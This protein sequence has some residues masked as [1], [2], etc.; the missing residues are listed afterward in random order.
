MHVRHN[1]STELK[2]VLKIN[3]KKIRS[4][5]LKSQDNFNPPPPKKTSMEKNSTKQTKLI[6]F[7][8][9]AYFPPIKCDCWA[10]FKGQNSC[11]EDHTPTNEIWLERPRCPQNR[12]QYCWFHG[13]WNALMD[14][15]NVEDARRSSDTN[16]LLMDR[17][18]CF[19]CFYF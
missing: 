12:F 2:T 9:V 3:K 8:P 4:Y 6:F 10:I 17:S 11:W 16:C 14:V 13:Y 5:W 19:F 15:S 7:Y 1:Q 18:S